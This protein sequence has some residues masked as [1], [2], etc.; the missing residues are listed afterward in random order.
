MLPLAPVPASPVVSDARLVIVSVVFA[1][2]VTV[3]A[4]LVVAPVP[5]VSGAL[6]LTFP[7]VAPAIVIAPLPAPAEF[8][9]VNPAFTVYVAPAAAPSVIPPLAPF[10]EPP[11][12]TV[13]P[14]AIV[15]ALLFPGVSVIA[16]LMFAD[17]PV[18]KLA[19]PD[20]VKFPAI[21]PPI[22]IDP[23]VPF[24][25]LVPV[26]N[27]PCTRYTA[28]AVAPRLIDPLL[29]AF[30]PPSLLFW[31]VAFPVRSTAPDRIVNVVPAPVVSVI[32]PLVA[33]SFP[34]PSDT[35]AAPV[36]SVK[37]PSVNA[38]SADVIRIDALVAVSLAPA[39]SGPTVAVPVVTFPSTVTVPP[40][41]TMLTF[42]T[43]FAA[44]VSCN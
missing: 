4:P 10:P 5:V 29:A 34:A 31:N 37:F 16:P 14:D 19:P 20:T 23:V 18:V 8:P 1:P 39:W 9:V 2:G 26:C 22:A 35:V 25:T 33:V 44:A 43:T 17:V 28:F 13:A 24:P 36:D 41:T 6:I 32:P 7:A 21:T 30:V 42:V 15:N 38:P 3:I 40:V 11:V 12:N 27:T